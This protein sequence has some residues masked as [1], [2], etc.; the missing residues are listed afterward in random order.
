M[1]GHITYLSDEQM[2]HGFGRSAARGAQVLVRA[3]V[4]DRVRTF[5]IRARSSPSTTTRTRT[6]AL[7]RRSITSIPAAAQGGD[8]ARALSAAVCKFLVVSFTTDWR[9]APARSRE[10]VKALVDN[11][12]DVSYAEIIAA[13]GHDAFLLDSPQYM[14][15][16]RAYFDRI[17]AENARNGVGDDFLPA[18][19]VGSGVAPHPSSSDGSIEA[20]HEKSSLTLLP[21]P[22]RMCRHARPPPVAP[23]LRPSRRGSPAAR[24]FSTSVAA[25]AACSPI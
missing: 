16:V 18:G 4:P 5:A 7:P 24:A 23:I 11:G 1:I 2:A 6:C 15:V 25:T 12:H 3:R 13:H 17:A 19:A 20:P 8:L 9:F 10:I 22:L 14:G 21:V